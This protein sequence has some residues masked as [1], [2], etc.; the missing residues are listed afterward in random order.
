MR[1]KPLATTKGI[2]INSGKDTVGVYVDAATG[3]VG[4]GHTAPV[5]E[6]HVKGTTYSSG[7]ITTEAGAETETTILTDKAVCRRREGI[8]AAKRCF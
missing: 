5:S 4:I 7:T 8:T 1:L 2:S 6:L 3:K